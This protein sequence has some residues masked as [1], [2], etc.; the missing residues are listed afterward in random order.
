MERLG[1]AAFKWVL[2][3][4]FVL[5]CAIMVGPC[6]L[7]HLLVCEPDRPLGPKETIA[8]GPASIFSFVFW[9]IALLLLGYNPTWLEGARAIGLV[10]WGIAVFLGAGVTSH[11]F[12]REK[13][14]ESI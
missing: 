1:N 9:L 14:V 13:D 4:V 5:V 7:W 8:R 3:A 11:W 6:M 12:T 10:I 2:I